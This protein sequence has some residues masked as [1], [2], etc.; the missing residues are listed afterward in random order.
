MLL[1]EELQMRSLKRLAILAIAVALVAVLSG[2][3][4]VKV[5]QVGSVYGHVYNGLTRAMLTTTTNPNLVGTLTYYANGKDA[6][7]VDAVFDATTG[8]FFFGKIPVDT[9]FIVEFADGTSFLTWFSEDTDGIPRNVEAAGFG[10]TWLVG[11]DPAVLGNAYLFPSGV[12]PGDVTI[13]IYDASNNAVINS[14]GSVLLESTTTTNLL[15]TDLNND[16]VNH[17]YDRAQKVSGTLAAGT[18]TILG[19][20]LVLGA[21]YT[22]EIYGVTGYQN[23]VGSVTVVANTASAQTVR[24]P[25]ADVLSALALVAA[26]DIDALGNKVVSGGTVTFTFNRDVELDPDTAD[27]AQINAITTADTDVDGVTNVLAAFTGTA[28]ANPQVASNHLTVTVSGK[29]MTI[30]VKA[31]YLSTEDTADNLSVDVITNSIQLRIAGSSES[32][33]TFRSLITGTPA[34]YSMVVRNATGR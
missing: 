1:E 21:T 4:I 23:S 16:L 17:W 8:F 22:I 27:T 3:Y 32:W 9:P 2:C 26:S 6:V 7:V 31:G 19:T 14:A 20:S 12:N 29:T 11:S 15:N 33:V 5:K 30:A 10:E 34:A 13:E 24:V 28:T 18:V 25:L